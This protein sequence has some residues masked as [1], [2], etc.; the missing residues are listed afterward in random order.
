MWALVFVERKHVAF[1]LNK[2]LVELCN[3][4][5]DLFFI[6]S[7]YAAPN[8]T[9]VA[10]AAAAAGGGGGGGSGSGGGGGGIASGGSAVGGGSGEEASTSIPPQPPLAS[11]SNDTQPPKPLTATSSSDTQR[12]EEVLKKFRRRE[13]NL[14][15][16][17]PA[18]ET[19]IDLPRWGGRKG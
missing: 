6:W 18:L 12:L 1:A 17:T 9:D 11:S 4:D 19:G 7:H 8:S 10:A 2:L 3:W 16:A 15:F 13:L 14:L 5:V